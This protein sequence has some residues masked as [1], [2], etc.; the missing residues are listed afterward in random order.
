MTSPSS[1]IPPADA[2]EADW[3]EQHQSAAPVDE[4]G[5]DEPVRGAGVDLPEAD[6]A[7]VVEQE[8]PAYVDDDEE[9]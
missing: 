2:P 8:I 1:E 3:A 5:L 6:E 4:A 9:A 7:D